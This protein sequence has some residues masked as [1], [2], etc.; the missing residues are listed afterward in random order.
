M[1]SFKKHLIIQGINPLF[2]VDRSNLK[3]KQ[4]FKQ[5]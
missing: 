3:V 1:I 4:V 2:P 5:Y